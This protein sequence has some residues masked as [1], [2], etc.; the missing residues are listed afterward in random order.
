MPLATRPNATYEIV[1][2]TDAHLPKNKQPVFVFRY[3]SIIEWE[4][5]AKLNDKFESAGN[6]AEMIDLAFAVIKKSLNGWRNMKMVSGT[7]IP[8]N[9]KKLKSM[10]SLQETTELMQ[11][12]V[13]QRPSFEDKKKFDSPSASNTAK[14]AKT[15][16]A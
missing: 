7:Q 6:A 16:K 4:D 5:I 15:A 10:L 14:S 12:A 11:A 2:S 1:L 9:I 13:A 8:F 3:L